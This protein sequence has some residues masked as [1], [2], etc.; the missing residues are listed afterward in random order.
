MGPIRGSGCTWGAC[1]WMVG[2]GLLLGLAGGERVVFA[3]A[4][5]DFES[6]SPGLLVGQDGWQAGHGSP[7]QIEVMDVAHPSNTS[8]V[9]GMDVVNMV[10]I[11]ATRIS[12]AAFAVPAFSSSDTHVVV[13]FD[14]RVNWSAGPNSVA[15]F[16]LWHDL[17]GNGLLDQ[18]GE[19]GPA[20]GYNYNRNIPPSL[21]IR[22]GG[23]G[24]PVRQ[25]IS[26]LVSPGD[27]LRVRM[28]ADLTANGGA[29]TGSLAYMNLSAG[30][31][32]FTDLPD[33]QDV[34]LNLSAGP[35]P[36]TWDALCIRLDTLYPLVG[37][38]N[39]VPRVPE[40]LTLGLLVVGGLAPRRRR[41]PLT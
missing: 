37:V 31:T 22:A 7:S 27:W 16:G 34:D 33:L 2:F 8:R 21:E 13:Q 15:A 19:M 6:L 5:Y 23:E 9:A 14:C 35:A 40:P 4:T 29:G 28:T 39:L 24:T 1:R 38:D 30:E 10:G 25:D 26:S 12:D 18:F 3:Q 41:R 32:A 20:F 36:E 11:Y 17:N